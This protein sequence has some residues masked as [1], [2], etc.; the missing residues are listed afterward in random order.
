MS[1]DRQ[2]AMVSHSWFIFCGSVGSNAQ[3]SNIRD[4]IA[5]YLILL[6][7]TNC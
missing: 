6:I 1:I 3:H 7:V 2:E 5:A 4:N